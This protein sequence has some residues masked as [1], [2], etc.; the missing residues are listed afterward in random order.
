MR[1]AETKRLA[2]GAMLVAFAM[3][4]SYI[5]SLVPPLVAIPGVKLGLANIATVFVLYCLGERYAVAV[6]LLR[7][8]LSSLLFGSAVSLIYSLT[9]AV[10]SL[11]FMILLR[12]IG[13]FTP[14]GVSAAGGVAH[15]AG[16]IICAA[17][18]MENAGLTY[19]LAPLTVAGVIT[20]CVIG[21]AAGFVI[22]KIKNVMHLDI[23]E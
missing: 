23:T 14:V 17:L 15:N 7:V 4:L 10:L 12:R 11:V 5:E 20:G 21:I 13:I 9:G 3:I 18:I 8:V 16:Q 6:S 19:Y 2:L 1:R 22:T